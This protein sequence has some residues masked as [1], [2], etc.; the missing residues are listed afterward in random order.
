MRTEH[1][2]LVPTLVGGVIGAAVGVGLQ[3]VLEAGL[4][5]QR[6]E[7]SWCAIVIG[8]LVGLGV[9]RANR[10]HLHR[11]YVRGAMSGLI[12]LAAIVASSF[13]IR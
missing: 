13:A 3:V 7:A 6:F 2:G 1:G 12:A 9:R 4:L 5:G 10:H 8:L 11:S